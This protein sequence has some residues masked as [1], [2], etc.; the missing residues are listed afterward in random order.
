M[1]V[2]LSLV[3]GEK[4]RSFL[5][6]TTVKRGITI[7]QYCTMEPH[8][9]LSAVESCSLF[10]PPIGFRSIHGLEARF[11]TIRM[12]SAWSRRVKRGSIVGLVQLDPLKRIGL[13]RIRRI[14]SGSLDEMVLASAH[15]N[16]TYLGLKMTKAEKREK[17]RRL[18]RNLHGSFVLE[19]GQQFTVL[20]CERLSA[21]ECKGIKIARSLD[22]FT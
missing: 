10:V 20:S 5:P 16:H 19:P 13:A 8:C 4:G 15:T 9:E 12:G 14:Q 2:N 1:E 11:S 21:D 22:S 18:V 7:C 3:R 17:L 6:P